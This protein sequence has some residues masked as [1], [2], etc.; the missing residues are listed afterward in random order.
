MREARPV[1]Y[2]IISGRRD[3]GLWGPIGA[4]WL[5]E[6]AERGG[7][8]VHPRGTHLGA[9]M[10]RGYQSA[11][12]RGFAPETVYGFWR[13]EVWIGSD[14]HVD[15]ERTIHSLAL[16]NDLFG[17]IWEP[18]KEAWGWERSLPQEGTARP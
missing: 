14:L 17:A 2:L 13:D 4:L 8:L 11:L 18:M 3:D 9:E 12:R 10:V 16:L 1:R 6:D 5:T 15:E 7:F